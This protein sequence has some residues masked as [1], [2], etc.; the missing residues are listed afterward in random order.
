MPIVIGTWGM[1]VARAH[2][3][4]WHAL[5][6]EI[7]CSYVMYAASSCVVAHD[8]CTY[9]C[10]SPLSYN[11]DYD[12]DEMN[13][14]FPQNELARAEAYHIAN[15]DNQY[16]VPTDGTPLRG[17]I[18]DHVISGVLLTM[19]DTMLT[20]DQY[21]QL[22][23]ST[24][25]D[26]DPTV[27]LPTP[28]PCI[29][30]PTPLWSGKQVIS[31]ILDL[32]TSGKPPLQLESKSKIP[33]SAWG[34][35]SEEGVVLIRQNE[36]IMGVLDKSAFGA[37][38]YGLVHACFELYGATMAGHLLSTLGRLFTIYLQTQGHTC[39]IDDMF[40]IPTADAARTALIQESVSEGI[41]TAA[42]YAGV[43]YH[44]KRILDINRALQV[45]LRAVGASGKLDTVMKNTL[46]S[47]TSR[48]ISA[49]LPGGQ[50]KSFPDNCMSLMTIS[51]AKGSQVNFSQISCLLGQ[52]ELEGK[53]VPLM[54]SGKTLPAFRKYDPAPRAGGFISDR[55]LTGK[56]N[57]HMHTHA[58]THLLLS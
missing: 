47:Y 56:H 23:F 17:L 52:Q 13:L 36:L 37:S 6:H 48:I 39:G 45:K 12:G 57:M 18:Q 38:P 40:V 58:R 50:V 4:G 44:S 42:A 21:Q 26:I 28:I 46:S 34:P 9:P 10:L 32:L 14:H 53:R 35:K 41:K 33:A 51:G 16:L 25:R 22:I 31:G 11:A 24:C 2:C 29:L 54:A 19:R 7:C 3:L 5:C 55:F 1:R 27:P 8:A 15:T 43:K 30:K 20:Q 49:C